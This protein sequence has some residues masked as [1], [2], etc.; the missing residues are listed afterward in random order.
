M[1][2]NRMRPIRETITLEAAREL[3]DGVIRPIERT[4]RVRLDAGRWARC[5]PSR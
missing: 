4:E 2:D 1:S 3:I 5:R